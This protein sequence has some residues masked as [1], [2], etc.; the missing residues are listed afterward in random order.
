ML[1]LPALIVATVVYLGIATLVYRLVSGWRCYRGLTFKELF[2]SL[3][4]T[5]PGMLVVGYVLFP[6]PLGVVVPLWIIFGAPSGGVWPAWETFT[7]ESDGF[8]IHLIWL[9]TVFAVV[10]FRS[11][12][13]R[14]PVAESEKGE[15][16]GA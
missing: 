8:F 4:F 15:N 6:V 7:S 1:L 12:R 9:A 14:R 16:D 10:I 5:Y 3:V 13:A 2:F 11:R